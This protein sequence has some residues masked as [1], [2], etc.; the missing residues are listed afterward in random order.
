MKPLNS[1][2]SPFST[3]GWLLW[4]H[5]GSTISQNLNGLTNMGSIVK[6]VQ[7]RINFPVPAHKYTN[8]FSLLTWS[9][10]VSQGKFTPAIDKTIGIQGWMLN[11]SRKK[12]SSIFYLVFGIGK[13]AIFV[14]TA[15]TF[16]QKYVHMLIQRNNLKYFVVKCKLEPFVK[17][18]KRN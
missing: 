12:K 8:N 17:F 1:V 15:E 10:T 6:K 5:S 14:Q 4:T 9:K 16:L 13:L 3:T 11:S 2:P 7:Q 18:Y